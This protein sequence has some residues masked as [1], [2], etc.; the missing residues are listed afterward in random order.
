MTLVRALFNRLLLAG[1]L[2]CIGLH[3]IH[4]RRSCG[5]PPDL[6]ATLGDVLHGL[7]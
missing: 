6:E 3:L 5:A 2:L 4:G 1:A 7:D